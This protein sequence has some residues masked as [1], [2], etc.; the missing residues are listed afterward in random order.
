MKTQ[1]TLNEA[2]SR[3]SAKKHSSRPIIKDEDIDFSDV[4]E[5]SNLQLKSMRRSGPGRPPLGDEP[6][7]MI[8]IKLDTKL[9]LQLKV[10]AK[11]EGKPYQSLIHDILQRYIRKIAA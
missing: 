2:K 9:L 10:E 8:S 3:L 7:K 11:K 4:P 5:L 1:M 6:R